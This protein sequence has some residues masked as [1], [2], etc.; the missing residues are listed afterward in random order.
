MARL[1]RNDPSIKG[2]NKYLVKRRDG[3]IP[4]WAWFVLGE[5]DPNAPAA[6][7]GYADAAEKNGCDPAYIADVRAL[8]DE[9]EQNLKT[10]TTTPGDPDAP[11]HRADDPATV[12]ELV[13]AQGNRP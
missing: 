3:T 7:R 4:A 9:W 1:W 8:A 10:G 12:A 5:R 2:G 13:A 11:R 6:L